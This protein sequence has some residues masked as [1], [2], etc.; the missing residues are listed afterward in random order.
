MKTDPACPVC[1][2][3]SW[4]R[5]GGRIY[6]T[7]D[8]ARVDDYT[9]RRLRVLFE[10]WMPGQVAVTLETV[11]CNNC[12]FL[13]C[14]PRPDEEDLRKKYEFLNTLGDEP[15]AIAAGEP[16]ELR[17][18]NELDELLSP[19]LA[20]AA[21]DVLDFGGGD[22]RLMMP[23]VRRGHRCAVLDYTATTV[24]GVRRLGSTLAD[25]KDSERFDV[26]VCNQVLEH[27]GSPREV[28]EQLR[29]RLRQ[30]GL[31]YAEVPME[32]WEHL[33]PGRDPVTHVNFF[34]PKSFR[35]L[36]SLAG[37]S[38]IKC[39]L[40]YDRRR[41][42]TPVILAWATPSN[43]RAAT[44]LN[45]AAEVKRFLRPFPA[46]ILTL[47]LQYPG[48]ISSLIQNRSRLR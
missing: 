13:M 21:R 3:R 36:L 29:G 20:G 1:A 44:L 43:G 42:A 33:P 11:L 23:L 14:Q 48:F 35:N 22:G 5:I 2:A 40:V 19:F 34:S 47:G 24:P 12:G 27:L 4:E 39:T 8:A 10:I 30:H 18:A 46:A 7:E 9:K 41:H 15:G 25:L 16:P 26:I 37:Y 28:L 32:L 17:R 38:V 6:R 45:A 31:L